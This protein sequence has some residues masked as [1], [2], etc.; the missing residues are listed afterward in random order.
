MGTPP[1]QAG[2]RRSRKELT[3]GSGQKD[4]TFAESQGFFEDSQ[5]S[6]EIQGAE[7]GAEDG[8]QEDRH[9]AQRDGAQERQACRA[10]ALVAT[11]DQRE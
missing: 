1:P 9:P 8:A 4:D 5:G 6:A 3:H 11:R 2:F 7:Q 10:E